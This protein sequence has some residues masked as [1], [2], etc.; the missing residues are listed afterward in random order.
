M[1]ENS[2]GGSSP[3]LRGTPGLLVA[4][5]QAD[6]FIPAP[7]GNTHQSGFQRVDLAVHPRAC[8]EHFTTDAMSADSDGSSPRLR[9]TPLAVDLVTLL[10]RFIPAPAGNTSVADRP[11]A[12]PPVHPRACGEHSISF[13]L[14]IDLSGSSPRLRGTPI[15]TGRL[16]EG[17]RFIPAP[18]GNTGMG[19]GGSRGLAV[20]PRACGEHDQHAGGGEGA[21]GSS[22]RLRGTRWYSA[23]SDGRYRFIPAPAGNTALIAQGRRVAAVH[24]RAC[25]EHS[26][27]ASSDSPRIGSSPR[28]R[29]T[30]LRS[31][32]V[33]VPG[34]F[35]PA[36]AG[37]TNQAPTRNSNAAV[38]PRACG[39][40]GPSIGELIERGGSS[41]RLRGT[42]ENASQTALCSRF[43]PAPAGNTP[44]VSV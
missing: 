5:P 42:P 43:I 14:L 19:R 39:E 7:A 8:G 6:R 30:H 22:P 12:S 17:G 31:A 33:R 4:H 23:A 1:P 27:A 11:T 24:P 15:G 3:R 37:N 26:F 35:I 28:L 20:H 44:I 9:G 40:H 13:C 10:I 32:A 41:P 18:A 2:S 16:H 25:G 36:P 34:R 38:H 21:D 29:G